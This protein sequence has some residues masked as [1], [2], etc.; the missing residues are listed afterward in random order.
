VLVDNERAIRFTQY[1]GVIEE[2][3][4]EGVYNRKYVLK[5]TDYIENVNRLR[6]LKKWNKYKIV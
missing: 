1:L 5:K 3:W 2:D 6:F 4:Q